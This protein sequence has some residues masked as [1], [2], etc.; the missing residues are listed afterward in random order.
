MGHQLTNT[1][2]L[3]L[4]YTNT[5]RM[6]TETKLKRYLFGVLIH[7]L[8]IQVLY[9]FSC[10]PLCLSD[11]VQF[12]IVQFFFW[13]PYIVLNSFKLRILFKLFISVP[14]MVYMLWLANLKIHCNHAPDRSQVHVEQTQQPAVRLPPPCNGWQQLKQN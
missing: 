3:K 7:S 1:L 13:I 12:C 10:V 11:R 8:L 5:N 4:K 6:K 14:I 9:L 2:K